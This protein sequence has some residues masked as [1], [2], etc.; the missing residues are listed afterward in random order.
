MKNS[1]VLNREIYKI[2]E[3]IR[4]EERSIVVL[5]KKYV[6]GL[7]ELEKFSH[8]IIISCSVRQDCEN[9]LLRSNLNDKTNFIVMT[10]K[11]KDV[12]EENGRILI[13]GLEEAEPLPIYDIKPYFPVED[14][15]KEPIASRDIS[16]LPLWVD[17]YNIP[18]KD[19]A[20]EN[21]DEN[22]VLCS[23]GKYK[24]KN[25]KDTIILNECN[26]QKLEKL[27]E[28]SHLKILWWFSKFEGDI[29]RKTLQANPP[30][31]GAPKTGVFGSRSP[32]RPNPIAITTVKVD[33][34]DIQN[35]EIYFYGFDAFNDTP[36]FDVI[37]YIPCL[38]RVNE[39]YVPDWVSHWPKWYTPE[40]SSDKKINE[41][42]KSQDENSIEK[43]KKE[44]KFLHS[45]NVDDY[46][47]GSKIDVDNITV[48]GAK[49]NNLK[50]ISVKI[51]KNRLTVITGLS[52]SGKSSLAFDTIYAEAQ[53]RYAGSLSGS[54]R[55]AVDEMDKPDVD[56]IEG[57]SPAV[58]I[59]QNRILRNPRSTV[60]TITDIYDYMRILYSKIG[61]RNCP[62]CGRV[63]KPLKPW[64]LAREIESFREGTHFQIYIEEES[65]QKTLCDFTVSNDR[66]KMKELVKYLENAYK[67]GNGSLGLKFDDGNSIL[68]SSKNKCVSCDNVFFDLRPSVFSYNSPDGMCKDCSGLGV[69]TLIEPELIVKNPGISILDGASDWWG[70]LREYLKKPSGNWM[71]GEVVA[72]AQLMNIDL[73]VPWRDLP[74]D[75]RNYILYGYKEKELTYH[76]DSP[77]GRKGEVTRYV[78]G[79]VSHIERLLSQATDNSRLFLQQ[80]TREKECLSCRGERL[81]VEGRHV[82]I[83]GTRYPEAARLNIRD[84]H[85]WTVELEKT[86]GDSEYE[87]AREIIKEIKNRLRAVMDVGLGYLGLDRPVTT[88]SGG[89]MQR[90]LISTRLNCGLSG[91][92]YVLDEPSKGLH[93]KDHEMIVD[94]L[95]KLS[96]TGNT[97]LV[98]EHEKKIM[99]AADYIIDMGPG[100]GHKGGEVLSFGIPSE[101]INDPKSI[102]G[103][104]IK[105]N[106]G[107]VEKKN[108]RAPSGWI[109]I[110]G[111]RLNNLKDIDVRIPTGVIA[112]VTGVSGSGKSSLITDTLVPAIEYYL[113]ENKFILKD[114]DSLDGLDIIDRIV[115]VDQSPIGKTPRS[116]PATYTEIFDDIRKMFAKLPD[117]KKAGFKDNAFSFNSE[118]G[119]CPSCK[120]MGTK[121]IDMSFMSDIWVTCE[122]CGG[123]RYKPEVLEIK[124]RGKS[125]W[126]ILDMEIEEAVEFFK[127][128]KKI[129]PVLKCMYDMGLDYIKLGQSSV[130]L[131]GG[132]AQRIK[133][134]SEMGRVKTGHTIYILDEPT[135]GLHFE[136]IK[137]FMNIID[138][139]V[140]AGNSVIMIEH[141]PSIIYSADWVI[142]LGPE[143]GDRGGYVVAEGTPEDI[144]S[145]TQSHTGRCIQ[146]MS[147][148]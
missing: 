7:K 38:D 30:Y 12:D 110:K 42:N 123:K 136:D 26:R 143:G 105:K 31:E 106:S 90:L 8:A 35:G 59:E 118:E 50:N 102:T 115:N 140:S 127:D 27:K 62:S 73:E 65:K 147:K 145:C 28:F 47:K 109:N 46:S 132:E 74:E 11:I 84:A 33:D 93:P 113:K 121:K 126:D 146:S 86:L 69:V 23:I 77:R 76:Y 56:M 98:V 6:K 141:N 40:V 21:S 67:A 107:F 72:L 55:L 96:D 41:E 36:V 131:S 125:I 43:Y 34:I 92:L 4:E 112:A 134:A 101:L 138:R 2:G 130:T 75:F 111:A 49:H 70:N 81:G 129:Y 91:L 108:R 18:L 45:R 88:L 103:K 44:N 22:K 78:Y 16:G 68:F 10:V 83:L 61:T 71:K 9:I 24:R 29:F 48:T 137:R 63:F 19:L 128:D 60:G 139:I 89:E 20:V 94:T 99:E 116:N 122:E 82:G 53:R 32:V 64:Q 14:R 117:A 13:D 5:D 37:P 148:E 15:V 54:A 57:L 39:F 124:L 104:Y 97:L 144:V 58:A 120:G 100:A 85:N 133:L 135:S 51:P 142:D 25:Q 66:G 79:A 119:C 114:F 1:G 87:I 80:F 17:E 95:K 52:G 3:I